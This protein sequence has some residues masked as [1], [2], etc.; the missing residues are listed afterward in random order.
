MKSPGYYYAF[1]IEAI[2][3]ERYPL[4]TLRHMSLGFGISRL[5]ASHPSCQANTAY[6]I[7]GTVMI[8]YGP[9]VVDGGKWFSVTWDPRDLKLEDEVGV[10]VTADG[11][12]HVYVNSEPVL[13]VGTSLVDE[14]ERA[15][16]EGTRAVPRKA[17]FPIVDLPGRISA[18]TL[19][20]GALPP[21]VP[22]MHRA[23]LRPFE[24]LPPE[25]P[26]I[27]ESLRAG[28]KAAIRVG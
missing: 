23:K 28:Q 25:D 5:P 6:E 2:D 16:L 24:A 14:A 10:L 20:P 1:R 4:D 26:A 9:H 27:L 13:R 18:V 22:K 19:L 7:Q 12:I 8:G 21:N 11:D 3:E 17:Y 15:R